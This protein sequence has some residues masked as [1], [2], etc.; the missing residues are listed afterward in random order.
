MVL[1]ETKEKGTEALL[2][3]GE[4]ALENMLLL[5]FYPY[6][7][8]SKQP[9]QAVEWLENILLSHQFLLI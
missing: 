8:L 5:L 1:C 9:R 3:K 2:W 4:E 7:A 6:Q